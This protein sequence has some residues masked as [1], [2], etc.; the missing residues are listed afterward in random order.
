[1][2]EKKFFGLK[3]TGINWENEKGQTAGSPLMQFV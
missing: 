2:T 3:N 1:M